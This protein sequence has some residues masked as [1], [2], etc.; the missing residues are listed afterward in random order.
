[1][2]LLFSL[3]FSLFIQLAHPASNPQPCRQS[4]CAYRCFSPSFSSSHVP[5]GR[6]PRL[7]VLLRS[8]AFPPLLFLP[9]ARPDPF[10][11]PLQRSL[12]E[13]LLA[14]PTELIQFT[15]SMELTL[16]WF[17]SSFYAPRLP[18]TIDQTHQGLLLAS[19]KV[20]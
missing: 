10:F 8:F 17:F 19:N 6:T 9:C 14:H 18:S 13:L 5:E 12:F 4:A 15:L 1:V 2:E 20:G 3:F 11:F 7:I 16:L